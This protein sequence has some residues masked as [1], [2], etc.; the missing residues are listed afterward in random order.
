MSRLLGVMT[1]LNYMGQ[2]NSEALVYLYNGHKIVTPVCGLSDF[3]NYLH[4][5]HSIEF[6]L[7]GSLRALGCVWQRGT[8]VL[9]LA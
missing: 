9:H 2:T 3:C 7:I 4:I 5:M 8:L 1:H 6:L